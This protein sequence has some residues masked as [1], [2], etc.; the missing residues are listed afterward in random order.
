[1]LLANMLSEP[2]NSAPEILAPVYNWSRCD[3]NI[4]RDI[5]LDLLP[6]FNLLDH[7]C[8]EAYCETL[9]D[10]LLFAASKSMPNP[11]RRSLKQAWDGDVSRAMAANKAAL[12]SWRN[13]GR[14]ISGD[15]WMERKTTKKI[16]RQALRQANAKSKVRLYEDIADASPR[17]S[18]LFHRLIR[19]QRV[20]PTISGTELLIDD[21][22]ITS[23]D[24]VPEAWTRHGAI[25]YNLNY[26]MF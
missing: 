22:L 1:M 6:V 26:F 20:N 24:L 5:I 25:D 21:K 2:N 4:Y 3:L 17:N 10:V 9:N 23:T 8:P 19:R 7:Q 16:L 13:A 18:R 15:T 12:M 11:I 14:P